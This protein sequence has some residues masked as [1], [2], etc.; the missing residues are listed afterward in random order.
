MK[1]LYNP[2]ARRKPLGFMPMFKGKS[3]Q[4]KDKDEQQKSRKKEGPDLIFSSQSQFSDYAS[5]ENWQG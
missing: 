5:T 4:R 1:P 2:V 3:A